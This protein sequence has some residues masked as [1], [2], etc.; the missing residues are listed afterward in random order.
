MEWVDLFLMGV[1][2]HRCLDKVKNVM[3]IRNQDWAKLVGQ[4]CVVV[5]GDTLI[6]RR[7]SVQTNAGCAYNRTIRDADP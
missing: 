4:S 2:E 5:E 3:P 7:I 6:G 1:L